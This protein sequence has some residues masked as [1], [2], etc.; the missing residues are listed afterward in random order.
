[1]KI[2]LYE[3]Y[4]LKTKTEN[5]ILNL[6]KNF[7]KICGCGKIISDVSLDRYNEIGQ[8]FS[9]ISNIRLEITIR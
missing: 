7:E 2:T 1:M 4:E 5:E 3:L 9:T 8:T 6:L